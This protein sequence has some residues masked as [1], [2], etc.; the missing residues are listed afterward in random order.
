MSHYTKIKTKLTSTAALLQALKDMG[1]GEAQLNVHKEAQH[2]QGYSGDSRPETA[3]IIIPRKSVGGASND[4]GF[5]LQEDGT[6]EAII[7]DYDKRNHS[8]DTK[9]KHAKGCNGYS[10]KWL[11]KLQQ[12]YT[13]RYLET[14][15]SNNGF[16]IEEMREE[17]GEIFLDCSSSFGG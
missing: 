11:K 16:F 9:S 1:F 3:E 6:Y 7:S 14:E 8:A 4:I 5:K 2:L 13:L 12:R 10:D 15:L 17:N